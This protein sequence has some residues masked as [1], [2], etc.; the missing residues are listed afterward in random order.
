M[1][2]DCR[3]DEEW[4][5]GHIE[6]AVHI[7]MNSIPHRLSYDPGA[8][9][10]QAVVVVVCKM[11]GRSAHVAAWLNQNGYQ[12][13]NLDGGMLAWATTGRAMITDDGS[14]AYVA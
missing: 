9:V 12:A 7:P 3:E 11:G 6:G 5:V 2:L 8:V 1:L 13:M 4:R 10:P 14:A